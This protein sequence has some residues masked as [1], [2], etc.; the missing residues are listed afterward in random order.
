MRRWLRIGPEFR[1]A[2]DQTEAIRI[3][4]ILHAHLGEDA[5]P[6]DL[7]RESSMGVPASADAADSTSPEPTADEGDAPA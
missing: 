3:D 4:P 7:P 5:T 6:T 2:A 1:A